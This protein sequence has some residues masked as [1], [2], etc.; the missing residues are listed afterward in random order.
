M[1][2]QTL[3]YL[4]AIAH[5][6]AG[7]TLILNEVP[8]DEYEQ[9]LTDLG[10]SAGVRVSYDQGRLEIMSPTAKHEKF[11][12]V[13]T[14]LVWIAAEELDVVVEGLGTTTYKQEWLAKGVEPDACFY[15]LNAEAIIGK[16]R[17][18]LRID[19]APDV[20]VEIDISHESTRKLAIYA[21]MGVPEVWRYDGK[22]AYI[23]QL[24]GQDYVAVDASVVIPVFT[25]EVLSRFL[26]QGKTEGQ[27]AVRRSFREWL[28][29]EKSSGDS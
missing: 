1:T 6:P 12:Q 25:T 14:L 15:I 4:D 18:D 11:A 23:Y 8:W 20:V 17:I 24:T 26:E 29:A 9:L 28:R 27:T 22:R 19:P 21:G 3:N 2:T 7:G 16:E 13:I 5:L 10:D